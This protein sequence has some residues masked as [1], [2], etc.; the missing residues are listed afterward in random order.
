MDYLYI[1]KTEEGDNPENNL[2]EAIFRP[3]TISGTVQAKEIFLDWYSL[4]NYDFS[5]EN[6][7]A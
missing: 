6:T 4:N 1:Y 7:T 2:I 3:L 5:N